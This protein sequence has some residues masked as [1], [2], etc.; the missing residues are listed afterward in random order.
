M[1]TRATI[2]EEREEAAAKA[3]HKLKHETIP[4]LE[5]VVAGTPTGPVRDSLTTANIILHGVVE[6]NL[7]PVDATQYAV[8]VAD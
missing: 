5:Q 7:I 2:R 8:E 3:L 6:G 1:R 4:S